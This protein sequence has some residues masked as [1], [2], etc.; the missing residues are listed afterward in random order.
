MTMT[1]AP[2]QTAS[3]AVSVP[4]VAA[5]ARA[6]SRASQRSARAESRASQRSAPAVLLR[7]EAVI[8]AALA[9]AAYARLGGGLG[10][11]LGLF[12]TPDL[13]LLG[14]LAGPRVGARLYNAMHTYLG[15]AALGLAA[16]ALDSATGVQ[17]ALIW[18]A[19]CGIDRT[20]GYG[21]KYT[22]GFRDTHLGRV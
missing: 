13:A 22:T 4:H 9:I 3:P 12:L 7:L 18:A 14:Y 15:P 1:F 8:I 17:L 16:H 10:L 11:F 6:Q 21:L 20:F 5:A 2:A 19:H